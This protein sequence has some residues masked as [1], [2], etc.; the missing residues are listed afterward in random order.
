MQNYV[1]DA[2]CALFDPF[3]SVLF[4]GLFQALPDQLLGAPALLLVG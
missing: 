1:S 2:Q 4:F 3:S